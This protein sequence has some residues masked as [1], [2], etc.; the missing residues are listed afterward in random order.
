M[1]NESTRTVWVALVAD[2]G[3]GLAKAGAA[4]LTGSAAMAAEA[5]HSLADVATGVILVVAW[6][7]TS[8]APEGREADDFTQPFQPSDE[9]G[10]RTFLLWYPGVA[11][12]RELLVTFLGPGRVW[13][14]VHLEIDNNLRGDQ[15]TSLVRGI[16][17]GLKHESE[18]ICRVDVVPISAKAAL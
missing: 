5:S 16:D 3:I 9:E 17:S 10:L 14:I 8:P 18:Y 13:V 2:L 4:V 15:I 7:L 11:A 6:S 1:P 12:I